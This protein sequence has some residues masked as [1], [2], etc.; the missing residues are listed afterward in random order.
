MKTIIN[1]LF[2]LVFLLTGATVVAQTPK[3]D[4]VTPWD[5]KPRLEDHFWRKRVRT[6]IDLLEKIN[7][8]MDYTEN[9]VYDQ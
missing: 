2:A 5:K 6:R 1:V 7:V 8:P 9:I 3:W 4:D